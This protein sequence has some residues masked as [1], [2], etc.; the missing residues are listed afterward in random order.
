[1][2]VLWLT[3]AVDTRDPALAFSHEWI[4]RLANQCERVD[5][6]ATR[7]GAHD[8]PAN[9]TLIGLPASE[10]G[11]AR[12]L[13]AYIRALRDLLRRNRYDASFAHMAPL[14]AALAGPFLRANGVPLVIWFAHARRS[15]RLRAALAFSS[16]AVTSFAHTFPYQSRKL[17]VIGQGVDTD[18][19]HPG[20]ESRREDVML[21]AGRLSAVKNVDKLLT[22]FG[23]FIEQHPERQT[24]L[25]IVGSAMTDADAAIERQL[26]SIERAIGSA[27]RVKRSPA[28]PRDQLADLF[29]SARYV[30]NLTLCGSGDKVALEA[31]SAGAVTIVANTDFRS[32]LEPY[33]DLLLLPGVAPEQIAATIARVTSLPPAKLAEIGAHLRER[34]VERHSLNTLPQRI[35]DV[36]NAV[37]VPAEKPAALAAEH[38]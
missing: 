24:A 22:G 35:L 33:D 14:F 21:Y 29:A 30:I 10:A 20:D 8:L 32:L 36:M 5:V 19:F 18:L 11:R 3:L 7:A 26:A 31:M 27:D 16:A 17:R 38:A 15:L 2:R 1:M 37:R 12:R 4:R 23:Q 34:V 25:K 6:I 13:F 28:V 9:V